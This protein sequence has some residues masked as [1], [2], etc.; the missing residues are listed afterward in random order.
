MYVFCDRNSE[1]KIEIKMHLIHL[2]RICK[3]S[4]VMRQIPMV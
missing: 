2:A 4:D 3:K 1:K